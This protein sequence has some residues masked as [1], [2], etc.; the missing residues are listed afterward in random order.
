M[1]AD[2]TDKS[3][4]PTDL[5]FKVK[6]RDQDFLISCEHYKKEVTY[7]FQIHTLGTCTMT[8]RGS[9]GGCRYF[10]SFSPLFSICSTKILWT[11]CGHANSNTDIGGN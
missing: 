1:F 5:N 7:D 11:L 8:L 6:V 10:C 4:V 2:H 9:T 3:P